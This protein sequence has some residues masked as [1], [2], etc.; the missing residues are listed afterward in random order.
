VISSIYTVQS[1]L[2]YETKSAIISVSSVK[3]SPDR[4]K[5]LARNQSSG[6]GP[7]RAARCPWQL[8]E[9]TACPAR[10]YATT[11]FPRHFS[12]HTLPG[13]PGR[14]P[15]H[16]AWRVLDGCLAMARLREEVSRRSVAPLGVVRGT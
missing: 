1:E 2:D 3:S 9:R 11:R 13:L 8:A 5:V 7:I 14:S 10:S 16:S 12:N 4:A 6:Q 15:T